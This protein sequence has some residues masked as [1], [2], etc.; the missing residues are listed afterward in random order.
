MPPDNLLYDNKNLLQKIIFIIIFSGTFAGILGNHIQKNIK[1][2]DMGYNISFIG[3]IF[4][5][6]GLIFIIPIIVS[7]QFSNGKINKYPINIP[8]ILTIIT[9]SYNLSINTLYKKELNDSNVSDEYYG[10]SFLY[11]ILILLQI[12]FLGKYVTNIF[13]NIPNNYIYKLS[14]YLFSTLNIILITIMRIILKYFSTDG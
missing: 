14:I 9:V 1:N 7:Y 6:M 12:I 13:N 11:N 5:I 10:Y 8:T 2:D 4:S 3:S